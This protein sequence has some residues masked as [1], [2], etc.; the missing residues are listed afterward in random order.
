MAFSAQVVHRSHS[1]AA[2]LKLTKFEASPRL[3]FN[4]FPVSSVDIH[5]IGC[6]HLQ[7]SCQLRTIQIKR[8]ILSDHPGGRISRSNI[9]RTTRPQH[10]QKE[11][12][13]KKGALYYECPLLKWTWTCFVQYGSLASSVVVSDDEGF[14][15]SIRKLLLLGHH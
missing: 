10:F 5:G 1:G 9:L 15:E 4:C 2:S 7:H 3:A 11:D 6:L 14:F 12:G 13:L 8:L